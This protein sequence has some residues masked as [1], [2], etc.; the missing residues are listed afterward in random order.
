MQCVAI[1]HLGQTTDHKRTRIFRAQ[2]LDLADPVQKLV[3]LLSHWLLVRIFRRHF[4]GFHDGKRLLPPL[5]GSTFAG[6]LERWSEVNSTLLSILPV[7]ARA[8]S[9]DEWSDHLFEGPLCIDL[10]RDELRVVLGLRC[11][12][13]GQ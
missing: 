9:V 7:T 12:T 6:L 8:V 1:L 3:T 11:A 10:L 2:K 5:A 4:V 13:R